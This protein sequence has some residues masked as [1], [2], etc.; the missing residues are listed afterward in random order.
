MGDGVVSEK[1][2]IEGKFPQQHEHCW[3]GRTTT[4]SVPNALA[5]LHCCYCNKDYELRVDQTSTTRAQHGPFA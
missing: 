3:H 2:V 5:A 1:N 4:L